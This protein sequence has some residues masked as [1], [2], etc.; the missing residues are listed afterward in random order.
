MRSKKALLNTIISLIE[1]AI[2]IFCG[3]IIPRLIISKFGSDVNGLIYSINQFLGYIVLL[4]AGVG[5][6]V[7]AALYKPLSL[8]DSKSISGIIKATEKFFKIIAYTFIVYLIIVSILLPYI[9]KSEFTWIFTF[10]LVIIIGISTF[11]QYYFGISYQILLQADQRQ[12]ITSALQIF[13]IIVNAILV[14]ILIKLNANI[15][16]VKLASSI[17]FLI[18]PIILKL[19]VKKKYKITSECDADEKAIEQRWDGLG[20]HIAFLIH[21]NTDI[22]LLTIFSS[23]KEVS[24]YSVY[25][26]I[27]SGV[28]TLTVTFSTGLEAAFGNMIAK[29][30]KKVL[31]KNF[32]IFE[33][34]SFTITTILFSSTA[35]LILPFVMLYTEGITDVNYYRPL[36]AYI[37]IAAEGIYCIRVPYNAIVLA[38]GH[39]KQTRNGAFVEAL[40][41]IIISA[42]LV[43]KLGIIGVVI[44]TFC[45]MLFRTIQYALYI[46]RNI[47]KR[48][49]KQFIKR[50][51]IYSLTILLIIIII[52]N[53]NFSIV[54]N[55]LEWFL[56]A[57]KVTLISSIITLIVGKIFYNKDIKNILCILNRMIKFKK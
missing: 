4:E 45:A 52:N 37:L 2:T 40:I 48:D 33:F 49:I 36:F 28:K 55:Y 34:I 39:Y 47:I 54:N 14:V 43:Y 18:R 24:V 25:F 1:Q 56:Y 30:E 42:V 5:G 10:S 13:T 7:R 44:G 17:I 57:I 23:V 3:V 29:G 15:Y 46:S 8:K 12:Y 20:H 31:E 53:L 21:N 51:L 19:Y 50:C 9:V 27:V 26:M 11:F 16:I 41:N 6:V 22:A 32:S 38:A 35:L